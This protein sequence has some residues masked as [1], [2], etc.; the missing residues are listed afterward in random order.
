ML[1]LS[2]TKT[3]PY[4]IV[5]FDGDK[6]HLN[7]PPQ[8]LYKAIAAID[9][10]NYDDSY[11]LLEQILNDNQEKKVV[12]VENI[13]LPL[14]PTIIKDYFDYWNKEIGKVVF[15]ESQQMTD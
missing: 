1:D 9:M 5:D 13:P 11:S 2:L 8:K 14:V 4:E 6:L 10:R 3:I 12:S 7:A 15:Q